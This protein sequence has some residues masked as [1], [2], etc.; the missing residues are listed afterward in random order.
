MKKTKIREWTCDRCGKTVESLSRF[1]HPYDIDRT[2]IKINVGFEYYERKWD[3]CIDCAVNLVNTIK[4]WNTEG[5][6]D[7]DPNH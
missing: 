6:K 5:K 1:G 7:R 3:L 2:K 4:T